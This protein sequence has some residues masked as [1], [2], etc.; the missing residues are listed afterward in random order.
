MSSSEIAVERH[1]VESVR[2]S[3]VLGEFDHEFSF[4]DTGEFS[5][6]F[7]PNGVGKTKMLEVIAGICNLDLAHLISIP[8]SSG[9]LEFTDGSELS[10]TRLTP[11][12]DRDDESTESGQDRIEAVPDFEVTLTRPEWSVPVK[13]RISSRSDFRVWLQFNSTYVPIEGTA[14]WRDTRDNDRSSYDELRRMYMGRFRAENRHKKPLSDELNPDIRHFLGELDVRLIE[15][16]RLTVEESGDQVRFGRASQPD[17][18][19]TVIQYSNR[20]RSTLNDNLSANSRL[21][22]QL[23]STF[24]RR[25]L[26]RGEESSLSEAELREKWAEQTKRRGRLTEIADLNVDK[27][28]SLPHGS[29]NSWQLGM[30]ELY[31]EDADKKLDSFTDVLARIDLL[32]EIVNARLLRKSLHIDANTGIV[33]TRSID[34]SA[35]SLT[36]LSS[37]EQHEIILMFDLL[38]NVDRG[39]LVLIDEPEISLH[40]GWQKKFIEDVL[41][42]AALVGFQF[43]VATHS[44]QIID[45]WWSR[46]TRL[47]P[48]ADDF[49][50]EEDSHEGAGQNA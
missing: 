23:D 45:R 26:E 30:L 14:F 6:V 31:L 44:P 37:G 15:T 41:R 36:S 20:I 42:I 24:P 22:Q 35:V 5:I 38:F 13:S 7:G 28:L 32:E 46:A 3:G 29:I 43:V 16:Q 1:R 33:V 17:R 18:V 25:M 39:S 2:V 9:S 34:G 10:L 12:P 47:G 40:I 21:T 49:L 27:E 8:F 50:G 48:T 19:P 11:L 4:K